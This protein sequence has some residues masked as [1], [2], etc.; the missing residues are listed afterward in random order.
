M[1]LSK[2]EHL[3]HHMTEFEIEYRKFEQKPQKNQLYTTF[4]LTVEEVFET[5]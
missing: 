5:L 4:H 2:L 3:Q 1:G